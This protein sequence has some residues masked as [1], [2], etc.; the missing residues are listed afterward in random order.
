MKTLWVF[1]SS[2]TD[3]CIIDW[4]VNAPMKLQHPHSENGHPLLRIYGPWRKF[5]RA[6][7]VTFN[8]VSWKGEKVEPILVQ[9]LADRRNV[10]L[11][12]GLQQNIWFP[13][14]FNYKDVVMERRVYN[15]TTSGDRVKEKIEWR[16][17]AVNASFSFLKISKML[18][19]FGLSLLSS[20]MQI[21]LR[22]NGDMWPLTRN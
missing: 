18:T 9:K 4:L 1:D 11:S 2:V 5:G 15:I 21:S 10:S 20:W 7:T 13:Q 19:G 16:I 6:T 3:K 22:R 8:L 17:N 12:C 14:K